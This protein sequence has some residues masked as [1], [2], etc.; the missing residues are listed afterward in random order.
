MCRFRFIMAQL[1][2]PCKG[3]GR[4]F[5]NVAVCSNLQI[6]RPCGGVDLRVTINKASR[7]LVLYDGDKEI[8]RTKV[9]L[10]RSPIG[11]KQREGDQKTPEGIYQ[12][13]LAKECGKYG[14]SLALNYPNAEDA[15]L[16]LQAGV[17]D[18]IT[19]SAIETAI[20]E[21]RRPPWGTAL[22]GEIYLHEGFVDTD[23]TAGCIALAPKDMQVLFAYRNQ[24]EDVA[25]LAV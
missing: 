18:L 20:A 6:V 12:I 16:A 9:A 13:C 23:W 25:I 11:A 15:R 19:C 1:V 3:F 5:A 2:I 4:R 10:G 21:G 8:L 17:I 22:G 7:L 24:I 14:L